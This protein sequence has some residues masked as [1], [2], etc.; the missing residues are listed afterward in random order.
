[1]GGEAGAPASLLSGLFFAQSG[2]QQA[3]SRE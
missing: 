2:A 3:D 1:M